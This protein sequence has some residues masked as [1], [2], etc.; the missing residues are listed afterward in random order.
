MFFQTILE[1]ATGFCGILGGF[2]A[3]WK[4]MLPKINSQI[5]EN[6][7]KLSEDVETLK[8][9]IKELQRHEKK[10]Y[11]FMQTLNERDKKMFKAVI[12]ILE[13][14]SDGNNKGTMRKL[15]E[16]LRAHLYSEL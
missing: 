9:E 13:H 11:L 16:E 6:T 1:I 8:T 2:G 3:A 14:L 10:D 15:Q 7:K 12:A 4:F 5:E